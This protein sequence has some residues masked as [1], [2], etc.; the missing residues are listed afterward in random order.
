MLIRKI[1]SLVVNDPNLYKIVNQI[2][3][4]RQYKIQIFCEIL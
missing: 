4:L 3:N 2:R 1:N